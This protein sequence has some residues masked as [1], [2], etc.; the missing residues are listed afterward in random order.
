MAEPKRRQAPKV[1]NKPV[2]KT[3]TKQQ[4]RLSD[5]IKDFTAPREP[6]DLGPPS[7]QQTD[8]VLTGIDWW[9][10]PR[11]MYFQREEVDIGGG[12]PIFDPKTGDTPAT[13]ELLPNEQ[14][15][16]MGFNQN[17]GVP[18]D[19]D[20][21][22]P[23]HE[24]AKENLSKAA[25][26]E[27]LR[28]IPPIV[29][30]GDALFNTQYA[31]GKEAALGLPGAAGLGDVGKTVFEYHDY[32]DAVPE[33]GE[34]VHIHTQASGD[35]EDREGKRR[36]W[37]II[38][39]DSLEDIPAEIRKN[40]ATDKSKGMSGEIEEKF[41]RA[42]DQV[43]LETG[44]DFYSQLG[45]FVG[46]GFGMADPDLTWENMNDFERTLYSYIPG[47]A[48]AVGSVKGG[49][50]LLGA[51]LKTPGA[52][53][54][55]KSLTGNVYQPRSAVV[56]KLSRIFDESGMA[57]KVAARSAEATIEKSENVKK[58]TT[59]LLI[60]TKGTVPTSEQVFR[61]TSK[62]KGELTETQYID[63][64]K[65]AMEEFDEDEV[66]ELY[67]LVWDA[68]KEYKT[69][70]VS[71]PKIIKG[72]PTE[73]KDYFDLLN[74]H[75]AI[76]KIFD[77]GE[78]PT[79][80]EMKRIENIF[81]TE[82]AKKVLGAQSMSS[83]AKDGFFDMWNAQKALIASIDLSAPG[84]QGWKL[85]TGPFWRQY[86]GAMGITPAT[87]MGKNKSMLNMM[88]LLDPELGA[89]RFEAITQT[90]KDNK[91]YDE[92]VDAVGGVFDVM[93]LSDDVGRTISKT[94]DTYVSTSI[95]SSIPG[96]KISERAYTGF[97]NKLRWDSVY[98]QL[99]DWTNQG[100]K[101]T[102]Q[103][104]KD[105]AEFI[106][107]STGRGTIKA[108]PG[109]NRVLN[110]AFFSP[111]FAASIPQFY[112]GGVKGTAKSLR[113]M[114][115][116]KQANEISK[117][118][119]KI[120]VSHV[121]KGMGI[122]GAVSEAAKRSGNKDVEVTIDPRKSDFGKV[123][124]GPARYDFW[125]GDAQ[126]V[127][128]ITR[129]MLET[130]GQPGRK[131]R[132]GMEVE[133]SVVQEFERF[134]R[135]KMSP[136]TGYFY[137]QTI[138]G[139]DFIGNEV[140]APWNLETA[141]E[142]EE[143]VI[144]NLTTLF[145]QDV[146]E[147]TELTNEAYQDAALLV[148]GL[149]GIGVGIYETEADIRNE[150]SIRNFGVL[151]EDLVSEDMNPEETNI[152]SQR[153]LD[154]K[155][156]KEI[157]KFRNKRNAEK[158]TMDESEQFSVGM[159][160]YGNAIEV[161]E[162][163]LKQEIQIIN[164]M[165]PEFRARALDTAIRAFTSEKSDAYQ[166]LFPE[167]LQRVRDAQLLRR[168]TK[169]DLIELYR[170]QYWDTPIPRDPKT[171]IRDYEEQAKRKEKILDYAYIGWGIPKEAITTKRPVSADPEINQIVEAW[172][173]D[174]DTIRTKFYDPVNEFLKST[175][176]YEKYLE[177]RNSPIQAIYKFDP[178]FTDI[179][180]A[181]QQ[182][183]EV[184]RTTNP[185]IEIAMYKLGQIQVTAVKNPIAQ[186]EILRLMTQYD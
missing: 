105:L 152:G 76:A 100:Y 12:F 94:E 86:W 176:Y 80:G 82:F 164:N 32:L 53:S 87:I 8:A 10:D 79:P 130:A 170:S 1:V 123:R 155:T 186:Q 114:A 60:D 178:T 85:M 44:D 45:R 175:G 185:E 153:Q 52:D 73:R 35:T 91:H 106:N 151:Y 27:R 88:G 133:S 64:F 96:V 150:L 125:G 119:A 131:S 148:P 63:D 160:L 111:R 99:D 135:S 43:K 33:N 183:K 2:D 37:G 13:A 31:I 139:E 7:A 126:M 95:V 132:S 112:Y 78:I 104:V 22:N 68:T 101:Y 157:Y 116:G 184:L 66:K 50:K 38:R 5:A 6:I 84:R 156:S 182:L 90:I 109:T 17:V 83:K 167:E 26:K 97:L 11:Q 169:E 162:L 71:V 179:L 98:K 3:T 51:I 77:K 145:I 15:L 75:K 147:Q 142:V 55:L 67:Q 42:R 115:A 25:E 140:T 49:G 174:N 144:R 163:Q 122:M 30:F 36:G 92:V 21:Y 39:V 168:G 29:R 107:W 108:S 136:T 102:K 124:I 146:I 46:S 171:G 177:Y 141:E 59:Q 159:E 128:F 48:F 93:E 121:A 40:D 110:A 180:K 19:M 70:G 143:E 23:Y 57:G 56:D 58:A 16:N 127:K 47:G 129:V 62:L 134:I 61:S 18:K 173:G 158:A 14:I 72:A 103:D 166:T 89:V 34:L 138:K 65:Q 113:D 20:I 9:Q 41:I 172:R 120:F 161:A 4:Q 165:S 117:L 154:I 181:V 69:K 149:L 137:D 24:L 54:A 74:N 118:Q 28:Q 81:G